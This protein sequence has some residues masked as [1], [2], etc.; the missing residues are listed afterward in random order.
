MAA[1]AG[2]GAVVGVGPSHGLPDGKLAGGPDGADGDRDGVPVGHGAD[3]VTPWRRDF[4]ADASSGGG[5]AA[6]GDRAGFSSTGADEIRP[7]PGLTC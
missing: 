3:H 2:V 1:G 6:H 5:C 4:M 7:P